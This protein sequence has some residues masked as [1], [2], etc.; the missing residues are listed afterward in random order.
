MKRTLWTIAVAALAICALR[1]A[2]L[3]A[4]PAKPLQIWFVDVE[5]G[6][7]T[8]IVTPVGE[9]V[10]VDT[11]WP[12][13]EDRDPRRIQKAA[14]LAGLT[15]IDH[16]VITH[17]H[18]DHYGGVA[19]LSR[20]MPIRQFYN[21]GIPDSLAEDPQGFPVLMAAYKQAVHGSSITLRPGDSI[22]LQG[23]KDVSRLE[24]TCL[25]ANG[26]VIPE[27]KSPAG[28]LTPNPECARSEPKPIDT[29]DNA[30]S[31]SLL[32]RFGDFCFLDCGDLTWN[33]EHKLV[34][35]VNRI[36]KVDLF[37]VTHHGLDQSNNPVLVRSIHPRVAVID[38]G[39]HKGGSA[40]TFAT[41]RS[42]PELEAIFQLH[43]NLDTTDRDN[44]PPEFIANMDEKCEGRYIKA[45]VSPDG[46][47]YAVQIEG[48]G[49]ARSY[50]TR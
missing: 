34:C 41:L 10:L 50:R 43:R 25:T 35:P 4:A 3:R 9:S 24:L 38:N 27:E 21:R 44:A 15:R 20:L 23:G 42:T 31:L 6:A 46:R 12:G 1:T 2:P 39:P 19:G 22:P 36:G 49:G 11:G 13:Y 7:A 30:R 5:G 47:R 45:E 33:V 32:L 48:K 16:L 40:A 37:Q 14:R 28:R 8:L 26:E 18:T 29:S 17:W